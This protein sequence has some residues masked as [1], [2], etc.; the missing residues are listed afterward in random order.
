MFVIIPVFDSGVAVIDPRIQ[1]KAFNAEQA[2]TRDTVPVNISLRQTRA[3][4]IKRQTKR[5]V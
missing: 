2:M 5:V 4:P 1:T 3:T